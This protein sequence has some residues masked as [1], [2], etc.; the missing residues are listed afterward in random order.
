MKVK[1]NKVPSRSGLTHLDSK[2]RA[3]MVDVGA[4]RATRREAWAGGTVYMQA[5][6]LDQVRA[7]TLQKGDVIG[8]AKVAGIL[9]A[10]KTPDLIPLCHPLRITQVDLFFS[11]I[12]DPPRIEIQSLVKARDRTGVEMEALAAVTAAALTIYDMCKAIDRGMI[13]G[14]FGVLRKTGGESGTYHR[15]NLPVIRP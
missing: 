8:V 12:P 10:K 2:G 5:E 7:N 9:A 3:Q 11:L 13:I 14:P 1:A 6:T 15:K 4:K